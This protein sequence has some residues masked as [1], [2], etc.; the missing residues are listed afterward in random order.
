MNSS[1]HH[2]TS[3]RLLSTPSSS[4]L[5][6]SLIL[7]SINQSSVGNLQSISGIVFF[8]RV[9]LNSAI[10]WNLIILLVCFLIFVGSLEATE[11]IPSPTIVVPR[12]PKGTTVTIVNNNHKP[13]VSSLSQ[14]N[15]TFFWF[16][17]EVNIFSKFN[18]L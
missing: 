5:N 16:Y 6:Q 18:R 11:S 14:V 1:S 13:S 4:P 2:Q 10:K 9:D 8:V 15:I 3:A 7:Q 12:K 17:F